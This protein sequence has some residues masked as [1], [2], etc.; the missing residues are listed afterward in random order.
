MQAG[1]ARRDS[2]QALR[3]EQ[4]HPR[5]RAVIAQTFRVLTLKRDDMRPDIS[6]MHGNL[7]H[8]TAHDNGDSVVGKQAVRVIFMNRV[9]FLS[10][11]RIAFLKVDLCCWLLNLIW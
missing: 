6:L 2:K 11:L 7:S 4:I 5:L 10:F 1:R 3:P 8:D 9:S